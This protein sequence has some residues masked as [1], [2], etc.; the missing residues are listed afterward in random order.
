[1]VFQHL[2]PQSLKRRLDAVFDLM[3]GRA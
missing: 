2:G 1:M 3:L